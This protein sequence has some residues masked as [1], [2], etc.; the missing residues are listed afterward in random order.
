ME[1]ARPTHPLFRELLLTAP[2]TYHHSIIVG[3]LAESAAEAVGADPMLVRVGAY[4][5]DVGK[6][7]NPHFFIENQ[8]DGINPHDALND[9]YKS[10]EIIITHVTEGVRLAQRHKLPRKIIDFIQ[11]HHGT[12]TVGWF[13]RKAIEQEGAENVDAAAFRYPGPKPQSREMA[14]LMLADTVEA[15]ARAVKPAGA[16]EIDQLI[17]KAIVTKLGEGQFDEAD[18]SL[19]DIEKIRRA[20]L[21][22]L[23]GIYH[24]RIAYPEGQKL[25][26][27]LSAASVPALP[28]DSSSNGNGRSEPHPHPDRAPVRSAS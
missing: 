5:H 6:T 2:G 26:Q 27:A 7:K 24:P 28:E 23:Q 22:I 12:T 21:N 11:E 3:N 13:H 18:L 14:I 15:T 10:A 17:R 20:F 9:P 16:S 8:T 1:L 4:Y 25:P 19:R